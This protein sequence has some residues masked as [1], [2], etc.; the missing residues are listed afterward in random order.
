[1]FS[2]CTHWPCCHNFPLPSIEPAPEMSDTAASALALVMVIPKPGWRATVPRETREK[3]WCPV[4]KTGKTFKLFKVYGD[5][6]GDY[7]LLIYYNKKTDCFS[8]VTIHSRW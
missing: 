3:P 7:N 2:T 6:N 5:Y 8:Q 4:E 1:M